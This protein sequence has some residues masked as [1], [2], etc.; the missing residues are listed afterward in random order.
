MSTNVE[1]KKFWRRDYDTK[2]KSLNWKVEGQQVES[3]AA[4]PG[5]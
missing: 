5:I 2:E 1:R 4:D 3:F